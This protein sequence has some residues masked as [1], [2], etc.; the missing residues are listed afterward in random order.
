MKYKLFSLLLIAFLFSH[1]LSA[2]DYDELNNQAYK[3]RDNKNYQKAIELSTQALNKKIN[4]RSYI[5]RATAK[6]ELG[7][8]Q[9]TIEDYNS[10]LS[11]YYDYY[12]TEEKEKG[13]IYYF[14]GRS[15]QLLKKYSEAIQ[16]FNESIRF[17]YSELGYLYWN[18]GA[19]FYNQ[20]KYKDAEND[21]I[22]AIDRFGNQDDLST[23][24]KQRGDCQA[25][26]GKYEDAYNLYDRALIYNP[27]NYNAYWQKAFYKG[28]EYKYEES[29]AGYNKAIEIINSGGAEAGD[30]DLALLY[31][32]K[33]IMHK[34]LAEYEDALAAI[35]KSIAADPNLARAYRT[36]ADINAQL[37]KY[38][39]AK[40][41]YENAITLEPDKKVKSNIYT[42]RY[43]MGKKILDYKSCL[44]DI[45]KAIETDPGD[46]ENIWYRSELYGYK[47][48]Y[49]LAIKDCNTALELYKN[50][51]SS[52]ASLWW[53]RAQHKDYS[54]DFKGAAED[55]QQ[56]LKYY[57][58]SYSCYYELGRLY[59]WKI[60][61]NDLANANLS[62]ALELAEN[63]SDTEKV[64][65]IKV[66]KGDKEAAIKGMQEILQ[67][68]P[69]TDSYNIKWN[70]HSMACIY[71]LSGNTAKAFEYL[72]KSMKAG[73]DDYLHLVNDRDL[74]SL[75]KLPQWKTIL[76]KYKVPAIK[77]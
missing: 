63:K 35:N 70:L 67:L 17:N 62:K 26:Q 73:F 40:A 66:V 22:K 45:Q 52:T 74:A 12:G 41:D 3:E 56:Y 5:I 37:K 19:C 51:S 72:D 53:L 68:T 61:S 42:D 48:N 20:G 71:A 58:N 55:Y 47:K 18:R 77:N 39:A 64:C 76:T 1:A 46:A 2:Q 21:Y 23:L 43:N 32:N 6:Y 13:G 11:Y 25:K 33:A 29:L 15:R 34:N 60:K 36:R 38:D 16:D 24:Y 28:Q 49:P 57:P 59:K 75:M 65:F 27:K 4:A 14:R 31:R 50:D 54:G 9:G 30:N 7:D 10:S 8:Y 44:A 69:E